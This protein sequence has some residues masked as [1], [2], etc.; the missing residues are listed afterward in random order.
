[1]LEMHKIAKRDPGEKLVLE[2][3]RKKISEG[4]SFN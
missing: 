3:S 2:F 1:V 4:K